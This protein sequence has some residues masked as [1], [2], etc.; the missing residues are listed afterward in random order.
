VAHP[1]LAQVSEGVHEPAHA[2]APGAIWCVEH[3]RVGSQCAIAARSSDPLSEWE[4]RLTTMT[5][6]FEMHWVDGG[7]HSFHVLKSSGRNDAAV[8]DEIGDVSA[9]WIDQ[10]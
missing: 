4:S 6:P 7:D 3:L 1:R 9:R 2:R 5:A 8:L 10:P